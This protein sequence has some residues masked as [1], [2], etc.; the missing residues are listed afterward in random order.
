MSHVTIYTKPY[1]P[2]C[3]RALSLL[4]QKG[5][6]FT[7]IE[8]G[9][10]PEKR[11]EMMRRAGGRATF[12]QI[13]VGDLHIGGCDEMMALERAGELDPLLRDAA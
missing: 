8:A 12:P 1:C 7:E 4:E 11:Q 6:A 10:D 3:V 9:F 2:Y 5:I 13:F